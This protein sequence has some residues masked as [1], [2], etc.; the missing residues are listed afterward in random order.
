LPEKLK[1]RLN[2]AFIGFIILLT[3]LIGLSLYENFNS[4]SY[5]YDSSIYLNYIDNIR[6]GN[7]FSITIVNPIVNEFEN[8]DG[9]LKPILRND[10]KSLIKDNPDISAD[11]GIPPLFYILEAGFFEL[12]DVDSDNWLY[13]GT[14]FSMIVSTSFLVFYYYFV[15]KSFGFSSAVFSTVLVLSHLTFL[16]SLTTSRYSPMLYLFIILA[17]L[18]INK[19]TR[20]Y[21]LFGIFA[22]LA[23]LTHQIAT[24]FI[25]SYFT[26]LLFKKE[27][28]GF[29]IVA[30]VWFGVV[31][32]WFYHQL[33]TYN[34]FGI[35]F[36]IP[37][38]RQISQ[39]FTTPI[40]PDNTQALQSN[41]LIIPTPFENLRNMF[42]ND[43]S[44]LF[45]SEIFYFFLIFLVFALIS[46]SKIRA[47]LTPK[48]I[49][50]FSL[51]LVSILVLV[52]GFD[53]IAKFFSL[54]VNQIEFYQ[55]IIIFVMPVILVIIP[56][57]FKKKY[58]VFND[59]IPRVFLVIIFFIPFTIFGTYIASYSVLDTPSQVVFPMLIVALPLGIFGF[60]RLL[61]K[62]SQKNNQKQ[63]YI[64]LIFIGIIVFLSS[65][66]I[67]I[68]NIS[69]LNI[70]YD[71]RHL[72]PSDDNIIESIAKIKQ[73]ISPNKVIMYEFPAVISAHTGNPAVTLPI[74]FWQELPDSVIYLKHFN[75][76]YVIVKIDNPEKL[77]SE[78]KL[79]ELSLVNDCGKNC[80]IYKV[81]V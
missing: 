71:Y 57:Y 21:I 60:R 78:I 16:T 11:Y 45:E 61:E 55:L 27:F 73:T 76:E 75:V 36:G 19:S 9:E 68:G 4:L 37:F 25:F 74:D 63:S 53:E 1:S 8:V 64:T 72:S 35:G 34:D 39:L 65:Y 5:V 29:L 69:F 77:T 12:F 31:S 46:T 6:N 62:F 32:F 50:F 79:A 14:A 23:N 81:G 24:P 52:I 48:N 54:N 56:R 59:K 22:G 58:D 49:L 47:L 30:S 70:L 7:G 3:I 17:F 42:T 80:W 44:T 41:L 67:A 40:Q 66:A 13:Y 28:K 2:L 15:R 43:S 51:I 10:Y 26:F 33:Q 18:F 20:D 38:S